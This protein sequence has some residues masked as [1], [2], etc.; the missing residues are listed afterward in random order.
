MEQIQKQESI[1]PDT[2]LKREL[3]E[4]KLDNDILRRVKDFI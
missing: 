2:L 3:I 4:K 1:S